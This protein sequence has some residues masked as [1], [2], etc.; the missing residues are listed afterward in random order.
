MLESKQNQNIIKRNVRNLTCMH[1]QARKLLQREG[2]GGGEVR[3][4]EIVAQDQEG[5]TIKIN[6]SS[7]FEL[8]G[9]RHP[10]TPS[11]Y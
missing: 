11:Y 2:G 7:E 5:Q 4:Q 8:E 10:K 1:L 3:E 9:P 6:I